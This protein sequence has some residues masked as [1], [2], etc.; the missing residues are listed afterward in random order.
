M[1]QQVDL[2]KPP[3]TKMT[4]PPDGKTESAQRR[5]QNQLSQKQLEFS[6]AFCM[7]CELCA[8]Y[9]QACFHKR[10]SFPN[11]HTAAVRKSG[12]QGWL[13]QRWAEG[14]LEAWEEV[15]SYPWVKGEAPD[16]PPMCWDPQNE[17]EE[18]ATL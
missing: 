15:E 18:S 5:P 2:R 1:A 8:A 11:P 14:T 6:Q 7:A 12:G 17:W 13:G 3:A 10:G 9:L 4:G 16:Q